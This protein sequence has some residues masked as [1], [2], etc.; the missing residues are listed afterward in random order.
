MIEIGYRIIYIGNP[1]FFIGNPIFFIG[2]PM[3]KIGYPI[4]YEVNASFRWVNEYLTDQAK[5]LNSVL[6]RF[7]FSLWLAGQKAI[8]GFTFRK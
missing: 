5:P 4:F 2:Y 1:I 6:F 3:I 7:I 8:N